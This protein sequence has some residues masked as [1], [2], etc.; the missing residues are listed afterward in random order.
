MSYSKS[1]VSG[2]QSAKKMIRHSGYGREVEA[3]RID[4]IPVAA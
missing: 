1:I 4:V 2:K 3:Q